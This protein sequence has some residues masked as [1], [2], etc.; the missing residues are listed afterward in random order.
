MGKLGNLESSHPIDWYDKSLCRHFSRTL[1][2]DLTR[3]LRKGLHAYRR[4]ETVDVT[5]L[6]TCTWCHAIW[7]E[8]Y[9]SLGRWFLVRLHLVYT[10]ALI[11]R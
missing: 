7:Q 5:M 11:G 10:Q 3:E 1:L 2:W 4:K 8:L 6:F 9:F